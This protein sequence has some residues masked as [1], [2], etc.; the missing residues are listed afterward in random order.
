MYRLMKGTNP[1]R[2]VLSLIEV[3]RLYNRGEIAISDVLRREN[4]QRW[5]LVG[6]VLGES[7]LG[8]GSRARSRRS[9]I[10]LPPRVSWG[11]VLFL[12]CVSGGIGLGF[13]GL[14]Q[15]V[16]SRKIQPRIMTVVWPV[17]AIVLPTGHFIWALNLLRNQ[18]TPLLVALVHI[19]VGFF[20][21]DLAGV[22]LASFG[23]MSVRTALLGR[24]RDK[25]FTMSFLMTA[26]FGPVYVAYKSE[27]LRKLHE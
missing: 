3:Q 13:V 17:C 6:D 11:F 4:E 1:E 10:P 14:L 5:R 20:T 2:T 8:S 12:G 18:H 16:W 27:E 22:W 23:S 15:G 19:V 26:L 7:L 9:H 24:F 25:G 21:A